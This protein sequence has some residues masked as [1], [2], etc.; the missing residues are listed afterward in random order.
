M[1]NASAIRFENDVVMRIN[2]KIV[3]RARNS[4]AHELKKQLKNTLAGVVG[5]S[6]TEISLML[7][8]ATNGATLSSDSS[9]STSVSS[10][11][12]GT[13]QQVTFT[14]SYKNETGAIVTVGQLSLAVLPG[15]DDYFKLTGSQFASLAL[16]DDEEVEIA[17]TVRVV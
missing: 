6:L 16:S 1:S 7:F 11:S 5:A 17:W 12:S 10:D 13:T 14:G 2:G 15:V 4:V 9:L 3:R 8:K